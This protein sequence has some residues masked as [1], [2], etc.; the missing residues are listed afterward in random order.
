MDPGWKSQR[1]QGAFHSQSKILDE[2]K[3]S[4]ETDLNVGH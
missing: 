3:K 2:K 4:T 1:P